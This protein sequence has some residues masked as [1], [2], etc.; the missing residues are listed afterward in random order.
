MLLLY[1]GAIPG[2]QNLKQFKLT[3]V[4]GKNIEKKEKIDKTM[5]HCDVITH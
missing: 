3:K 4:G 1:N 5:D 2:K